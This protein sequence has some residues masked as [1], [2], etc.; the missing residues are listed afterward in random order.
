[1]A[2]WPTFEFVKAVFLVNERGPLL[3]FVE[4]FWVKR[5]SELV[6]TVFVFRDGRKKL[7]KEP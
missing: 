7:V 5:K 6:W 2:D 1:M 3:Y 4:C